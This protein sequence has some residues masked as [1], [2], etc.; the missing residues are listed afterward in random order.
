MQKSGHVGVPRE[1]LQEIF[2]KPARF[3]VIIDNLVT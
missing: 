3:A 2:A 1:H